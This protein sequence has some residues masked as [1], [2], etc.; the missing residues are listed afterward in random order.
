MS[1]FSAT[2][3]RDQV[4][5]DEMV[6]MSD[7]LDLYNSSSSLKQQSGGRHVAQLGHTLLISSQL[8]FDPFP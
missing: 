7:F 2:S 1:Y 8:V 3:W 5:F 6:M 4:T